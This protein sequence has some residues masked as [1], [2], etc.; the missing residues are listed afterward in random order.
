MDSPAART[1]VVVTVHILRGPWTGANTRAFFAPVLAA[2]PALQESGIRV[3]FFSALSPSL[4]DCDVL[5]VEDKF[6]GARWNTDEAEIIATLESL[7][8]S[9]RAVIYC[10]TSDSSGLIRRT[11]LQLTRAYWKPFL[12]R[13]RS[14]Y[15]D[16]H[17][18]GRLFTDYY[19]RIDGVADANPICSTPLSPDEIGRLNVSW[20]FGL[21]NHGLWGNRGAT[22]F[23]R[24]HYAP[25]LTRIPL[26]LVSPNRPRTQTISCRMGTGHRRQTVVHQRLKLRNLLGGRAP[27]GRVSFGSF[28]AEMRN[29]Q[30]VI[31]PFG[32]GEFAYRDYEAFICGATLLKPDMSHS[33]T[34]PNFY[35][36]G[37]TMVAFRWDFSDFEEQLSR[38]L[39]N[40]AAARQMAI[41]AQDAYKYHVATEEGRRTFAVHFSRL[42]HDS[43]AKQAY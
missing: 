36:D 41:A 5:I 2:R 29:S 25:L 35:Q 18:G 27:T 7:R 26:G 19:H 24:I 30:V 8:H 12:L 17:Y 3:S 32:W 38:T 34:F 14:A 11:A 15:A 16:A 23:S 9:S 43:L 31:S 6:F 10:D 1:Q 20:H 40:P 37:T 28:F 13:D 33:E 4:L 39:E 42:V 22:L 21:S